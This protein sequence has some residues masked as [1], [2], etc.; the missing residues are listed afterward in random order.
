VHAP[1]P[2]IHEIEWPVV[3][4]VLHLIPLFNLVAYVLYFVSGGTSNVAW[5]LMFLA[6]FVAGTGIVYSAEL[7][8]VKPRK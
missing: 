3:S 7:V 8:K 6:P 2:G 5:T 1:P 4:V